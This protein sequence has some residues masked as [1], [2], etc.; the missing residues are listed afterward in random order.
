MRWHEGY[1]WP[2]IYTYK[3]SIHLY[4]IAVVLSIRI[5][6]VFVTRDNTTAE[7]DCPEKN[8]SFKTVEDKYENMVEFQLFINV[9]RS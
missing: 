3:L 6:T 5:N 9:Y 1:K 8:N 2:D 7:T 4:H